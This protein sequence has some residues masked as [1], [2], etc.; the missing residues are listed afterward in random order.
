MLRDGEITCDIHAEHLQTATAR[1]FWQ[2]RGPRF[3]SMPSPAP[4]VGENHLARLFAVQP[5][6]VPVRP[7]LNVDQFGMTRGF[8]LLAGMI[9][10]V[11]H[12]LA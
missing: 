9:K 3:C 11:V 10:C 5:E 1:D 2:R 6:V 8:T 12:E 7:R 4:A